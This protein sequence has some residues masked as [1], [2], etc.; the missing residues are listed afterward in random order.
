LFVLV[1]QATFRVVDFYRKR[2]L[3]RD[4]SEAELFRILQLELSVNE[5]EHRPTDLSA[6]ESELTR[7]LTFLEGTSWKIWASAVDGRARAIQWGP[8]RVLGMRYVASMLRELDASYDDEVRPRRPLCW[9][10]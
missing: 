8:P 1:S 7:D 9:A 3:A 10:F 4:V 6:A 5:D 2:I